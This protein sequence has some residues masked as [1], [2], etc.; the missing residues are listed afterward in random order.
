[1]KKIVYL[2]GIAFVLL[3]GLLVSCSEKK[4][5]NATVVVYVSEDQVFSEPILKG[6][7]K[8]TGIKVK[9]IYDTEE[10]KSTGTKKTYY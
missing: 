4:S 5:D 10:A 6:F 8:E 3:A 7:E 9:A 2:K 1:M